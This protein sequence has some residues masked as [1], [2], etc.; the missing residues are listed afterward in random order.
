MSNKRKISSKVTNSNFSK[1]LFHMA[2]TLISGVG[3]VT[4]ESRLSERLSLLDTSERPP[5]VGLEEASTALTACN[6]GRQDL[7][8]LKAAY[9]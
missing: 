5:L 2:H 8:I 3:L 4:R 7:D 6:D 1:S 9:A